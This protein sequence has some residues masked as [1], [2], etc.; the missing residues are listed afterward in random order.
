MGFCPTGLAGHKSN[1]L[2]ETTMKAIR[3]ALGPVDFRTLGMGAM[4]VV[5]VLG[6]LENTIN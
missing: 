1:G 5:S 4:E 3:K 2:A 6:I